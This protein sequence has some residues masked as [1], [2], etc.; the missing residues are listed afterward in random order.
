MALSLDLLFFNH[1]IYWL[2]LEK[3]LEKPV[4]IKSM[5]FLFNG[6][7]GPLIVKLAI[8]EGL[9]IV[10]KPYSDFFSKC[11]RELVSNG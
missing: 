4:S 10:L 5:E 1:F 6:P 2:I 7:E 3:P 9:D 11:S 8:G